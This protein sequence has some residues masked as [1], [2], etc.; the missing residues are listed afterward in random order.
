MI[1]NY[2]MIINNGTTTVTLAGGTLVGVVSGDNLNFTLGTGT[3]SNANIGTNKTVS[4]NITLTGTNAH[5]YTLTQPTGITVE[6]IDPTPT[7]QSGKSSNRA[8][9]GSDNN[10]HHPTP[11]RKSR[12]I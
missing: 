3:V 9:R 4:T 8:N 12:G 7:P 6:I 10:Q 5:N 1:T 2:G 11:K